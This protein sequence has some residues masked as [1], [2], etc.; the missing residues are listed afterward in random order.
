MSAALLEGRSTGETAPWTRR[1]GFGSAA[2]STA[3]LCPAPAPRT[4]AIL[5]RTSDS[6]VTSSESPHNWP[7]DSFGSFI[8]SN[9][10]MKTS[11]DTNHEMIEQHCRILWKVCFLIF[12]IRFPDAAWQSPESQPCSPSWSSA[13]WV[14]VILSAL[15][16]TYTHQNWKSLISLLLHS[17]SLVFDLSSENLTQST[18]LNTQST[19]L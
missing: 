17:F 5:W 13:A 14:G 15:K 11:V 4:R 12:F 2:R 1:G 19:S 9:T 6:P 8:Q 7:P 3:C 18:H 10:K 16:K